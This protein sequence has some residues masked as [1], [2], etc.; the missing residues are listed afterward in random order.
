MTAE[1]EATSQVMTAQRLAECIRLKLVPYGLSE[2]HLEDMV[3]VLSEASLRGLDTHGV[4]LLPTY[5]QELLGGRSNPQ[6]DFEYHRVFPGVETLDADGALGGVAG[7]VGMRRAIALAQKQGVAAVS[8]SNSNHFGAASV[9]ALKAARAGCLALCFSNA[10]ALIAPINGRRK[11]LGTNP[12]SMACEGG[13]GEMFCLDMAC[14][15]VAYSKVMQYIMEDKPRSESW[16]M[17][18][19]DEFIAMKGLGG[20]KG[21]GLA[22]AV[23]ILTALLSGSSMDHQMSHLYG[24]PYDKPRDVSHLIICLNISAFIEPGVFSERLSRLL[25]DIRSSDEQPGQPIVMPGDLESHTFERRI[26]DGIPL[27]SSIYQYLTEEM[28]DPL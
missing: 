11:M 4:R 27:D 2:E 10:D 14:S 25:S 20:Y 17:E 26:R 23:Q 8:V 16:T 5:E 24:G 1:T 18:E 3:Y 9:Y 22:I 6:P 19:N 13:D 28:T 12:I 7:S 21:V 15:Q